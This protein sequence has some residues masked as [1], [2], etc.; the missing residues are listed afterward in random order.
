MVSI[1]VLLIVFL[2]AFLVAASVGRSWFHRRLRRPELLRGIS[3][4]VGSFL[5][6]SNVAC[7][8]V[9]AEFWQTST[10][11]ATLGGLAAL[12]IA[13]STLRTGGVPAPLPRR[14]LAIGAHPDDLALACGGTLA[15]FVDS[16]HE[17]QGLVMSDGR[18]GGDA[19]ER[20]LDAQGG[21]ALVGLT[22]MSH[23][24]F[25][26]TE[27]AR[28]G[29]EMVSVIEA[30]L[31]RHNPDIILT[32]SSHDQHQDHLA[33]HLATLRAARQHHSILCY[34][35]VRRLSTELEKL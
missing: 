4:S 7:L 33:V 21:A 27:L 13:M 2:V 31:V 26:A 28:H 15:K 8:F 30:A 5:L 20:S 22:G 6:A 12:G 10:L 32:H 11:T 14:V 16:G 9:H 29:Q 3:L 18:R 1:Y 25:P 24:N 23:H 19:L 35:P 34:E 17:V